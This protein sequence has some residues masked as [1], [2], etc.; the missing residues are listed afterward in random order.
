MDKAPQMPADCA[1]HFIGHLQSNK[2]KT[3]LEAAPNLAM[4]ETVDSEKLANKLDSTGGV[5][6]VCTC[7]F[8]SCHCACVWSQPG[9]TGMR[10]V[11]TFNYSPTLL[12]FRPLLAAAV[13]ALGRPPLP[14]F[15]QVNTSGEES[16]HGVEPADC[17]ALAQHIHQQCKHLRFAGL[18]TI[19]MPGQ[20]QQQQQATPI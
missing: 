15:V 17:L 3:L 12:F 13:A 9:C 2:V 4:L 20:Q 5:L 8:A 18:M 14:V 7:E 16:K 1:W 19:G 11:P 6:S 10:L